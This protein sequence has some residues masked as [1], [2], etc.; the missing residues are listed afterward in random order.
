MHLP[1]SLNMHRTTETLSCHPRA[2]SRG[3]IALSVRRRPRRSGGVGHGVESRCLRLH[4]R[5]RHQAASHTH[6]LFPHVQ[7]S[8]TGDGRVAWFPSERWPR[9]KLQIMICWRQCGR[10]L[11]L[12]SEG[13]RSCIVEV[14]ACGHT[15]DAERFLV[16]LR[17]QE[18][19]NAAAREVACRDAALQGNFSES[20]SPLKVRAFLTKIYRCTLP[21]RPAVSAK[22]LMIKCCM[23][24]CPSRT[25]D[26]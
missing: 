21:L 5:K 13:E 20:L 24:G 15:D 2:S 12:L 25:Q 26:S 19:G 9:T 23:T 17:L 7:A 4:R 10:W 3:H 1:C 22:A 8:I 14:L 18:S 11:F 6:F 16:D